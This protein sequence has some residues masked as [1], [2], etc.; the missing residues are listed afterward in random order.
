[1][2]LSNFFKKKVRIIDLS[3]KETIGYCDGYIPDKDN[4]ISEDSIEIGK[5]G[6]GFYESDIQSIE[7]V[8]E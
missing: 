7:I 8:E 2:D 5:A 1:M 4:D 3:G 6:V